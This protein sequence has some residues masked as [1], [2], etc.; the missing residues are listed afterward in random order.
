M[1]IRVEVERVEDGTAAVEHGRRGQV[2]KVAT[3]VADR[4]LV[5]QK[6]ML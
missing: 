2:A 5:K 1:K 6:A 3:A 4:F